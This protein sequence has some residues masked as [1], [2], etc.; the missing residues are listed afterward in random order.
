MAAVYGES[1]IQYAS[2]RGAS[3]AVRAQARNRAGNK[4]SHAWDIRLMHI[5]T[6]L[7]ALITLTLISVLAIQWL[8]NRGSFAIERMRLSGDMQ[9]VNPM[10]LRAQAISKLG[11]SFFTLDVMQAKQAFEQVPW[12]RQ[13]IV[14]RMW[15]KGIAVDLQEHKPVALWT[16]LTSPTE[17]SGQASSNEERLLNSYAE[18]FEANLDEVEEDLPHLEGT[19]GTAPRVWIVY[20]ALN[21]RLRDAGLASK[22]STLTLNPRGEW[23]V[24]LD[25][26]MQLNLGRDDEK[27]WERVARY[28]GTVEQVRAQLAALGQ[29]ATW[30]RIDLRHNQGYAIAL[31]NPS[32]INQ[33]SDKATEPHSALAPSN[34]RNVETR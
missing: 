19:A 30:S 22:V 14:K 21:E 18:V 7:L 2:T 20:Q 11:G 29:A 26:G 16:T 12:V 32:V 24:E 17:Q 3:G 23:D 10:S 27:L 9:H 25:D 15:P 34:N 28:V 4:S 1:R 5:T 8:A 33:A 6:L 31:R 13:A